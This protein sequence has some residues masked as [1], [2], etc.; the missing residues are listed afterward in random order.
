MRK[1]IRSGNFL[2]RARQFLP[3]ALA[4][5]LSYV[6][7]LS[8]THPSLSHLRRPDSVIQ[9]SSIR[10]ATRARGLRLDLTHFALQNAH[11]LAGTQEC[12][13]LAGFPRN[14]QAAASKHD[15]DSYTVDAY[16]NATKK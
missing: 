5:D 13:L 8:N 4:V 2:L 16:N 11:T 10:C 15:Q 7:H 6:H 12:G 9:I 3:A 14:A 1:H